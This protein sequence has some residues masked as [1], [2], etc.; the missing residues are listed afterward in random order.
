MDNMNTLDLLT[1]FFIA[2]V[3][4]AVLLPQI[5]LWNL[6]RSRMG[7][8]KEMEQAWGSKV[9]T[10]VHKKEAISLFGLPI[11]QFIDVE[12][13]EELLRGIRS[14]GSRP[15][16]VIVHS[17]GGQ[18]LPSIQIARALRN[19]PH[20]TRAIIPHYAMSGGTI[21]ALACDE[22]VMDA[23]AVIGPVDPQVGDLI[24]GSYPAHSW[25]YATEMKGKNADDASFVMRHISERALSMMK[26]H[27]RELLEGRVD[28]DSL[29]EI[30]RMLL[31]GEKV[32]S[33]PIS[34]KEARKM[35]LFVTTEV[36]DQ[37]HR[38]MSTFRASKGSVE[39]LS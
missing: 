18:L 27:L 4:Y 29:G 26:D 6:R 22:M 37:V 7:L 23:D 25:I 16:D 17:P 5:Q 15:I 14:A 24:R 31:G 2:F 38:Y 1:F 12:D 36:P 21:I 10:M 34:S 30:D 19:H 3:L 32:H 20:K 35:G 33:L 28:E 39:Y 8:I 13:A 11:Y 9:L